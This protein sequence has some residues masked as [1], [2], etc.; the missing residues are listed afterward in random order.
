MIGSA[1]DFMRLLETLRNGGNPLLSEEWVREMGTIQTGNLPWQVGRGG[2]LDWD[3][4]YSKIPTKA[5]QQNHPER[6]VS[7][8]L[9]VIRGSLIPH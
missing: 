9:T 2:A 3:S 5:E 1:K 7:E 8:E 6:G 4:P